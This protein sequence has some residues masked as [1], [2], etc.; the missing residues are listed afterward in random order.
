MPEEG[1]YLDHVRRKI[2]E[3][4]DAILIDVG[5]NVGVFTQEFL[6]R[7]VKSKVFG[8]EPNR[9]AYNIGLEKYKEDERVQLFNLGIINAF[10]T[11]KLFYQM[12]PETGCSSLYYREDF[13]KKPRV[14]A[15]VIVDFVALD[16]VAL[17]NKITYLKIDT[18]GS[19][20]S[21]LKS[22]QTMINS[23]QIKYIQFESG[24]CNKYS[25]YTAGDIVLW[26][27]SRGYRV[28]NG[29]L[30]ILPKGWGVQDEEIHNYLA[31]LI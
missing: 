6:D 8:F 9:D 20:M 7:F 31:E 4:Q 14:M 11:K 10:L 26:L 29:S 19:E 13:F 18:E 30:D 3:N 1:L 23:K 16:L 27:Q 15:E 25:G 2:P 24:D 5:F 28:Y 17:P 22:A 21:V 12:K